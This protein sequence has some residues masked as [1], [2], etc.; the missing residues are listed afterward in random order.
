MN[1]LAG[2]PDR[3]KGITE[4]RGPYYYPITRTYLNELLTDRGEYVNG[5]KFAGGAF[6][7]M[8]EK[9]CAI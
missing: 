1:A 2:K 4:I 5:I 8:P 7:L 3:N 6:S 9:S